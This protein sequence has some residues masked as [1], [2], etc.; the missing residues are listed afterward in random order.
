[1]NAPLPAA[2][3]ISSAIL[4]TTALLIA[5]NDKS[6]PMRLQPSWESCEEMHDTY[7]QRFVSTEGF[8]LSRMRGPLMLD[9][10]GILDLGRTKYAIESLDLVGL[11]NHDAP[12][13]YAPMLHGTGAS[14]AIRRPLTGFETQALAAFRAG[15]DIASTERER[16]AVGTLQCAGAIRAQRSCLRCHKDSRTG[17][18]LGAFTYRLKA[19]SK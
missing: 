7:V 18:L 6:A 8:G 1:M 2:V 11:L 16:D 9:R 19:I 5:Q 10:S 12:V 3:T 14:G 4:L 13:V 15:R 17:D